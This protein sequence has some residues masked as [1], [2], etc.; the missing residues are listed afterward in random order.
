MGS[1][2]SNSLPVDGLRIWSRWGRD[3]PYLSIPVLGPNQPPVHWVPGL[4]PP[5][6]TPITI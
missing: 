4:F 5:C 2:W 3:L 1:S 6:W